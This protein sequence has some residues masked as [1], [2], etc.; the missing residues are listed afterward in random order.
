MN[1]LELWACQ[2][3]FYS[4]SSLRRCVKCYIKY[5]IVLK[6]NRSF[7]RKS[8]DNSVVQR[9]VWLRFAISLTEPEWRTIMLTTSMRNFMYVCE[10]SWIY[11]CMYIIH[12]YISYIEQCHHDYLYRTISLQAYIR[13]MTIRNLRNQKCHHKTR[14][15]QT[16]SYCTH[17]QVCTVNA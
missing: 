2:I 5:H 3:L 12:P 6:W 7:W 14:L 17:R 4:S 13:T 10:I 11:A 15:E 16:K 1:Y 8:W 9:S